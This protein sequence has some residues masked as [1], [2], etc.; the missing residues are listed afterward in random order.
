MRRVTGA[1]RGCPMVV[2]PVECECALWCVSFEIY[3]HHHHDEKIVV[4]SR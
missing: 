2:A 3:Y 4:A 1:R